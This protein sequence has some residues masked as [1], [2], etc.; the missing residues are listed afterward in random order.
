V[1][2]DDRVQLDYAPPQ[3]AR[4][5]SPRR[6]L[7]V[8]ACVIAVWAV[9]EWG[10]STTRRLRLIWVQRQCASFEYPAGAVVYDSDQQAGKGLMADAAN[11]VALDDTHVWPTSGVAR[12]EPEC[13]TSLKSIL[14]PGQSFWPPGPAAPK[15]LVHLLRNK[16]GAERLVAVIVAPESSNR[17][18]TLPRSFV[19]DTREIGLVAAIIRPGDWHAAPQWEGNGTFF[20]PGFERAKRLRFFAAAVDPGDPARFSLDYEMDGV[21]G[22]VDGTF[23]DD[24]DV[25]F[26]IRSGPATRAATKG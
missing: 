17:P 8:A 11:Y 19:A 21:R 15:A 7:I 6:W 16:K 4:R 18:G 3:Q 22:T 9:V 23:G 10:P 26:A 25:T 5:W 2:D 13:W 1:A 14:F 12:R 24:G 20:K